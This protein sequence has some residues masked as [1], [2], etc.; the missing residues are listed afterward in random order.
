LSYDFQTP[1]FF[2]PLKVSPAIFLC[3]GIL[4]EKKISQDPFLWGQFILTWSGTG[5]DLDLTNESGSAL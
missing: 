4:V 3:R 1:W 2:G 5:T